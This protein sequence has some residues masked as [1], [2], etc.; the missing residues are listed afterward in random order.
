MAEKVKSEKDYLAAAKRSVKRVGDDP[1]WARILVYARNKKGKTTFS[2]S[3][4]IERTLLIDP[5]NGTDLLRTAKPYIWP[6]KKW[7]DM[8][9]VWGAVRTGKLSPDALGLGPS[10]KPFD[11][12]SID[13]TTRLNNLALRYIMR[14]A[15]QLNLDRRPG[16]VD[17]RDYNKSGELMKQM[18]LNFHA[19]PMHVIYTAQERMITGSD[20]DAEEGDA[21]VYYVADLPNGVRGALNGIV[22]VIGRL[23]VATVQMKTAKG[24]IVDRKQRRLWVG[25]HDAYDTGFRS[26][27]Q[28][29]D[30]LKNPTLDALVASMLGTTPTNERQ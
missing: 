17:R 14:Q 29:P 23:Y 28:M 27:F 20:D 7:E 6:V 25:V 2:L 24:E 4:G 12:L 10:K 26:E 16:I 8:D 3:G 18:L 13:G 5:E 11:T 30:F 22:Q 1:F 9:E 15:E 19:L 21:S